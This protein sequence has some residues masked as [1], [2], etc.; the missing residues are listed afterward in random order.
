MVSSHVG[1]DIPFHHHHCNRISSTA[2]GEWEQAT[3]S[4]HRG[5][6]RVLYSESGLRSLL[7][8]ALASEARTKQRAKARESSSHEARSPSSSIASLVPLAPG[9]LTTAAVTDPS[10]R[11]S[12]AGTWCYLP[13]IISN[14]GFS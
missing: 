4:I 12:R 1:V 2:I 9:G 7:A 6:T 11:D 13:A 10:G 8:R 5:W 3:S 14:T